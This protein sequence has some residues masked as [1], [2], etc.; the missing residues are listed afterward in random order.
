MLLECG[1]SYQD[2][3]IPTLSPRSILEL[4]VQKLAIAF[5]FSYLLPCLEPICPLAF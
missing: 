4:N 5:V 3:S 2:L 1:V